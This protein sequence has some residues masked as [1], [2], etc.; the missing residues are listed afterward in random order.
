[1][2]NAILKV[3]PKQRLVHRVV[4]IDFDK[5]NM[6]GTALPSHIFGVSAKFSAGQSYIQNSA[7]SAGS[8]VSLG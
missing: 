7:D 5:R 3:Y 8:A 2:K 4:L 1:L 6:K